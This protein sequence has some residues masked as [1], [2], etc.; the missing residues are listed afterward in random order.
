MN[1]DIENIKEE[2]ISIL[3][4]G[5]D[6]DTDKLTDEMCDKSLMGVEMGFVSRDLLYVLNKV[7]EHFS[8][9]IPD[10]III[11]KRF[12]TINNIVLAIA[13]CKK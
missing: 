5:L 2:L 6:I 13:Q 8:V 3:R 4:D 1:K 11:E 10:S 12:S 7:E 9:R